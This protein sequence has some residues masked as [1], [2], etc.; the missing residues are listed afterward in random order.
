MSGVLPLGP[1]PASGRLEVTVD[2]HTRDATAGAHPIGCLD[3]AALDRTVG[4]LTAT[5]ATEVTAG[6]HTIEA[7]L[8]KGATGTAVLATTAVPG[9][10][11]TAPV[12]PFHGLLAVPLTPGTDKVSCTFT[13]KGLPRPRSRGLALLTLL[14]VPLTTHF[15]RRRRS[16]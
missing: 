8:P 5:G 10:Q 15:R 12:R 16:L 13:P 1:V 6:G 2:T 7:T 3:R 14:T 9:W 11:C 4:H